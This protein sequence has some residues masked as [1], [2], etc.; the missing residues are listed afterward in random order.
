[1]A[2]DTKPTEKQFSLKNTELNLIGNINRRRD[3]AILDV[4]SYIAIE[5]LAYNVTEHTQFRTDEKGDLYISEIEP[6]PEEVEV[7]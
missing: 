5:R 2:K 6:T 3:Q 4:F 1:M 7:A